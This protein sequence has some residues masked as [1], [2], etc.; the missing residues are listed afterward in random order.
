ML[1]EIF[2]IRKIMTLYIDNNACKKIIENGD[3]NTKL[4]HI[5]IHYHYIIDNLKK[6]NI[7]IERAD[8]CDMLADVLTKD[9]QGTKMSEFTNKIFVK[10]I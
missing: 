9:F 3:I 8:S 1:Y 4:K 6:E 7:N 10:N 2:K 5:N